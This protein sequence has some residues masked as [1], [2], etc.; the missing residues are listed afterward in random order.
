[1]VAAW[2]APVLLVVAS[3][4]VGDLLEEQSV[5]AGQPMEVTVGSR[6]DDMRT[7]VRAVVDLGDT[8]SLASNTSGVVTSVTLT[9]GTEPKQGTQ[10]AAVNYVPILAMTGSSPLVRDLQRGDSGP[11]VTVLSTFLSEIGLLDVASV[12]T[13]FGAAIR[14]AVLAFQGSIG[15][16]ADGVFRLSYVAYVPL[17]FGQATEVP[18]VI[19]GTVD[20]GTD[21]AL[22]QPAVE[23]LRF[24]PASEGRSLSPLTSG[25]TLLTAG[26]ATLS[27][28]SVTPDPESIGPIVEWLEG[29]A[30]RTESADQVDESEVR[31]EE[32]LLSL[33][34]PVP[35][36]TVPAT[37]VLTSSDGTSC[38]VVVE[39]GSQELLRLASATLISSEI[40]I[41]GVDREYIGRVIVRDA[42]QAKAEL[43]EQ[44]A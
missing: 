42:A 25:P 31:Y 5:S 9:P 30:T 12:S 38:L 3:V 27:L 4:F 11:D 32:I 39:D 13:Q 14:R 15:V 2:L 8:P 18:L 35:Y 7:A 22:G 21:L 20:R 37:A 16:K 17:D 24:E 36:G 23:S 26:D 43:R 28:E 41:V 33:K 44:C 40:G 1:L 10:I 29:N 19:G 34:E 6:L